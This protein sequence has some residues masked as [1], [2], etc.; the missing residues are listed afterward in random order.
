MTTN[1]HE[2]ANA[3]SE[4]KNYELAINLYSEIMRAAPQ[5]FDAYIGLARSQFRAQ[6]YLD[7]KATCEKI[8]EFNKELYIPYVIL[9]YTKNILGEPV[10][11]SYLLAETA[12]KLSPD[13]LG[14]LACFGWAHILL[15]DYSKAQ[16]YLES[17]VNIAPDDYEVQSNL[18]L[19][20]V[21][22]EKYQDIYNTMKI[23]Y[24]LRP[25]F[26]SL[27]ALMVSFMSLKTMRVVFGIIFPVCVL[28]A[29][30][31][32]VSALLAIPLIYL[33]FI[34]LAALYS[35]KQGITKRAMLVFIS[36]VVFSVVL[37]FIGYSLNS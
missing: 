20:Y 16:F 35:M 2:K 5:D 1:L 10:S 6:K 25:S 23:L 28:G 17:A 26:A 27:Y 37:I 32:K 11:E 21:K 14:T 33:C 13:T 12:Y 8:I 9:S 29:L 15:E 7:A 24:Q 34:S 18:F 36:S 22:Q 31:L 30:M 3:A 4:N 19:C